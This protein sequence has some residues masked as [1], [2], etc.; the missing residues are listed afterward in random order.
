MDQTGRGKDKTN[1]NILDAC[2]TKL[3]LNHYQFIDV[4]KNQWQNTYALH[5]HTEKVINDL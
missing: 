5:M 4:Y 3:K 1:W 2:M